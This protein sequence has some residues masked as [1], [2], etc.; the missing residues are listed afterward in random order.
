MNLKKMMI[1]IYQNIQAGIQYLMKPFTM[2]M[3]LKILMV[4]KDLFHLN[5]HVEWIEEESYFFR[6]SKWEKPLLDYYEKHP[7]F[8]CSRI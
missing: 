3:K 2:K 1:F 8:Y 5:R 7:N 4:L 6:L